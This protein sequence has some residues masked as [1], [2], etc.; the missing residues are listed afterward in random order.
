MSVSSEAPPGHDRPRRERGAGVSV[1][2]EARRQD[3]TGRDARRG[4]G[5]SVSSEARRQDTPGLDASAAPALRRLGEP[6][7][8]VEDGRGASAGSE[9]V[10]EVIWHGG[11]TRAAYE[12]LLSALFAPD[13]DGQ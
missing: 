8:A 6:N 4:A 5:V 9:L 13:G 2:S 7:K 10:A 11:G 3:T 12:A 1:S